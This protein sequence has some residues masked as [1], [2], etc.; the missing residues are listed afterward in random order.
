VDDEFN[1]LIP[2]LFLEIRVECLSIAEDVSEELMSVLRHMGDAGRL[3][4]EPS[5]F[6][7]I[8]FG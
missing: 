2:H 6:G 4:T 8:L 7:A 1:G 5:Q 3:L